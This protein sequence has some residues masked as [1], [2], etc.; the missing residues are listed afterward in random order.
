MTAGPDT[1]PAAQRAADVAH[2]VDTDDDLAAVVDRHGPPPTWSRPPTL[3]TLALQVLEQQ[4][5]LDA[6]AAHF[7]RL[8]AATGED[9]LSPAGVLAL[10]DDQ[11]RDAGVSRQKARYLRELATRLDDGRLDLTE[12]AAADDDTAIRLLTEVPGI[13]P[14]TA[15]VFLLFALA[16]RDLFPVG[17]RALQVGTAEVLGLADA[18]DGDDLARIATRWAPRRS[19]AAVLVWHAYLAGRGRTM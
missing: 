6:A 2:L 4:I 15:S 3:A 10:T 11:L 1:T 12:V 19:A 5:S 8:L 7:E 17:D 9:V 14:W 18:P 13:G 16:R